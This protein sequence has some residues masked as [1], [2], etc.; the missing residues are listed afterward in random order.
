MPIAPCHAFVTTT[1]PRA[2]APFILPQPFSP[3]RAHPPPTGCLARPPPLNARIGF[4]ASPLCYAPYYQSSC[5]PPSLRPSCRAS[6]PRRIASDEVAQPISSSWAAPTSTFECGDVGNPAPARLA[7]TQTPRLPLY[8]HPVSVVL[9]PIS[10]PGPPP[11]APAPTSPR[12]PRRLLVV[13]PPTPLR[14]PRPVRLQF[15]SM[16]TTYRCPSSSPAVS[17][18]APPVPR[19]VHVVDHSRR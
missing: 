13:A 16:K 10:P 8:S 12:R 9:G 2:P 4:A 1:Y 18:P 6:A 17:F 14:A 5:R 11:S 15:F 19:P 3:V 7:N